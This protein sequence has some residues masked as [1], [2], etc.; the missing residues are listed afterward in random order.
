MLCCIGLLR[1]LI[2]A[3][4][5]LLKGFSEFFHTEHERKRLYPLSAFPH[6]LRIAP[7]GVYSL[8][9]FVA[10]LNAGW[11]PLKQT[12]H[13]RV[14]EAPGRKLAFRSLYLRMGT[15]RRKRVKIYTQVFTMTW[16]E[17]EAWLRV[18]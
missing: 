6:F 1:S 5:K 9:L 14:R 15:G 13:M 8:M 11:T 10:Q 16:L 17:S 7:L 18:A 2:K 4:T 3:H 12:S